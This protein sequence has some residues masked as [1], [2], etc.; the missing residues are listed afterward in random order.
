MVDGK[1]PELM[2]LYAVVTMLPRTD[3]RRTRSRSVSQCAQIIRRVAEFP[4]HRSGLGAHH[5]SVWIEALGRFTG[6]DAVIG[7]YNATSAGSNSRKSA[8]LGAAA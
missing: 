8:F 6:R 2:A 5:G 4:D 7:G 1:A 3:D